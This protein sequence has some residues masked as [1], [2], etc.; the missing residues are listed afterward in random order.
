M[1]RRGP[2]HFTTCLSLGRPRVPST[3]MSRS[4]SSDER[5]QLASPTKSAMPLPSLG[6]TLGFGV[7][8]PEPFCVCCNK[9]FATLDLYTNH[10]PGSTHRSK[11]AT[12]GTGKLFGCEPLYS[13]IYALLEPVQLRE[14][15]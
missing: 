14:T 1:K 5:G 15:D 7:P 8:E 3:R 2:L 6:G 10:L 13:H 12:M 4:T 9:H 11:L